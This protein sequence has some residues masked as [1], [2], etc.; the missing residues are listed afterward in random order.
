[1]MPQDMKRNN[2]SNRRQP[3]A[4]LCAQTLATAI[5]SGLMAAASTSLRRGVTTCTLP[6]IALGATGSAPLV[7][8]VLIAAARRVALASA[9]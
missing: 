4:L 3:R 7:K 8:H 9:F 6:T 5:G 1:M 2:S